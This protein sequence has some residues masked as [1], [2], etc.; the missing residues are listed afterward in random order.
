MGVT[1][2]AGGGIGV[3]SSVPS[4]TSSG[5]HEVVEVLDKDER[6]RGRGVRTAAANVR[7]IIAPALVGLPVDDQEA[8]DETLCELDGT[9]DLSRLG[10]NAVLAVS[11]AA[12]RAGAASLSVP[13]YR[14]LGADGGMTLPVPIATVLAGGKHSPSSLEIEDY[15]LVPHG[16]RRFSD[17]VLALSETRTVLEEIL[18]HRFG[19]VPDVGGALAPPLA[20]SRAA[21]E[22]MLEAADR[23]GYGGMMQL[24]V[25]VAASAFYDADRAA[26]DFEGSARTRSDMVRYFEELAKEFPLQ[27]IED[28]FEEDDFEGFA[29]LT[30][31]LPDREIVGDDLF[32]SNA[33]RIE[34]GIRM[35]AGN[36]VLLKVNQIGTVSGILA[37]ARAAKSGAFSITVSLRSSDTNDS[38]IADLAVAIGARRIKL[39][40]PVRG[41]RNAKYNRLLAIEHEL[42]ASARL[43]STDRV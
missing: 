11:L 21:F 3:E 27:F 20:G 5:V 42:G 10:A 6:Y 25:D 22:V 36:A 39:G 34:A 43:A 17:V 7:R 38:F 4:G 19:P 28:A 18:V 8:I 31:A 15:L 33:T 23:A 41:E 1:L 14:Y 2:R 40:S 32:V 16:I 13:L 29:E 26:Y 12:A 30:A 9:E 24:G 37:A 35:G